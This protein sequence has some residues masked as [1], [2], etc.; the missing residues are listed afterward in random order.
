MKA[1]PGSSASSKYCENFDDTF[2][3]DIFRVML[4]EAGWRKTPAVRGSGGCDQ[5]CDEIQCSDFDRQSIGSILNNG[6]QQRAD[7]SCCITL[8]VLYGQ[9]GGL[10]SSILRPRPYE[11][12]PIRR[13][14]CSL[15]AI[16]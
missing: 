16:D 8:S 9:W 14:H 10:G 6:G 11:I 12:H 13:R 1:P 2:I 3:E 5:L 15:F 4:G 7:H